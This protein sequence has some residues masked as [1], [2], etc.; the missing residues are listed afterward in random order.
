VT[1]TNAVGTS[2]LS[3]TSNSVVPAAAP[4]AP[5]GVSATG[6]NGEA[7]ITFS[8]PTSTS[9]SSIISYTVT[10]NVGNFTASGGRFADHD[11]RL[12]Q[13]HPVHLYRQRQ[14]TQL[15]QALRPQHRIP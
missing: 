4:N 1:A 15:A 5:T 8:A 12:E 14:R 7:T 3:G 10:S 13:W 11:H 9:G 2:T 6:G